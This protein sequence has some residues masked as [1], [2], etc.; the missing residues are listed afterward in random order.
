MHFQLT[1][2]VMLVAAATLL[3]WPTLSFCEERMVLGPRQFEIDKGGGAVLCAW[4]IY[5][6]LQ[7]AT[8]DCRL[9]R[10]PIDDAID[11]AILAIDE[12][13][14]ANSSLRPTRSMLE[15]F[16]RRATASAL[17]QRGADGMPKGCF[18]NVARSMGQL[19]ENMTPEQLRES[20]RK[21]LAIP[22]EPV[23]NPCL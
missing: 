18:G 8:T 1:R 23:M 11:E 15:E 4:S 6:S 10:R 21:L 9:S 14:M 19:R 17:G 22:R 7:A 3:A 16:K 2:W 20:I 5:L 12:F 13:I